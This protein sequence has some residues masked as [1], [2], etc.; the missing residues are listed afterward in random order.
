MEDILSNVE[1][2]WNDYGPNVLYA[3][4]IL[5]VT[6]LVAMLVKWFL[7]NGIDRIP[8]V[9]RANEKA[10]NKTAPT[11]GK[12]FASAGFWIVILIGL[13]MAL[14]R[15]GLK[16]ISDSIRGTIDQI[17]AYL[18]QVIGAILTFFIFFIVARVAKQA[19][20]ASLAAAQ[21][22]AA[23]EKLGLASGPVKITS[24]A[25][26]IVFALLLIPGAIAAL[27]V[28][29]IEAITGPTVAML[30]EVTNAIPNILVAA[31]VIGVFSLVAKFVSDLLRKV[32]PNT[33]VDA[34]LRKTGLLD[35]ADFNVTASGVISSTA[36]LIILLLG[37]IQGAQ[38]LGFEPLNRALEIVLGMGVQI[39]FGSVI[40]LAGV[41]ISG[42][43]AKAIA[44]S[45]EGAADIAAKVMR[46]VI[47]I[48]S[49]ILGVSRMGLDPN[50]TFI[51]QASLILLIGASLAGGIAFG[52]G[53]RDWAA[54]QLDKWN[55]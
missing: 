28:L 53:G 39:I 19:T 50:G 13:V 29:D 40:I 41:I 55:S 25:G 1:T 21:A 44:A 20:T 17:F 12:S 46:G 7:A 24:M 51:I 52:L 37:L 32:L 26:S 34:A 8:F 38:T 23:P 5:I 33:G 2:T 10:E 27:Q 9:T 16:T 30:N 47:V 43:V 35:G 22:D 49:V 4:I 18:P 36:G 14:E 15:L 42:F 6:Y 3:A 45:G 54:K 31:I 48:L 11:I